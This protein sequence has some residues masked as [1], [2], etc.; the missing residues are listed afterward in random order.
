MHSLVLYRAEKAFLEHGQSDSWPYAAPVGQKAQRCIHSPLP[1]PFPSEMR[2][3]QLTLT[4][5]LW[6]L[7]NQAVV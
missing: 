3:Q 2:A 1:P 6:L 7:S 4:S 5:G